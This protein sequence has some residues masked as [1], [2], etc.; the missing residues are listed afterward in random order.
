M[1]GIT[2]AA[3]REIGHRIEAGKRFKVVDE[4]CLIVVAAG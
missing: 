4:M 1:V 2:F 3:L